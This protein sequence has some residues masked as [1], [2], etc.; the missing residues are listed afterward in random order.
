MAAGLRPPAHGR[1]AHRA[2]CR[3]GRRRAPRDPLTPAR[4]A[5]PP[6]LRCPAPQGRRHT[7]RLPR[8]AVA[9]Q[10]QRAGPPQGGRPPLHTPRALQIERITDRAPGG[11]LHHS[12]P[13]RARRRRPPPD[14]Q[15][16]SDSCGHRPFA[17]RPGPKRAPVL[18]PALLPGRRRLQR[19][20]AARLR[21]HLLRRTRCP[22]HGAGEGLPG[23]RVNVRPSARRRATG[24]RASARPPPKR[25][26]GRPPTPPHL[27]GARDAGAVPVPIPPAAARC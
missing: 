11:R 25:V 10:A 18:V 7:V 1:D 20:G 24:V 19:R 8:Q 13:S 4:H 22:C 3:A 5:R 6:H 12:G 14:D 16:G 9:D 2:A 23:R 15:A 27:A 26:P 21:V 17:P